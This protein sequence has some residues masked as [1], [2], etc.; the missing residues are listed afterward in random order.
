[1]IRDP[2]LMRVRLSHIVI[3]SG[4]I[5]IVYFNTKLRAATILTHRGI[6]FNAARDMNFMF[7]MPSVAVFTDE[8]PLLVRENHANIYRVDA[9]FLAKN[10]AELPQ[11][12]V[13]PVLYSTI[14]FFATQV[15]Q[16][17][18]LVQFPV[19]TLICIVMANMALSIGYAAACIFGSTSLAI[20]TLPLFAIPMMVYGGF[21]INLDYIPVYLKPFSYLSWY[22]YTMEAHMINM[23]TNVGHIQDCGGPGQLPTCAENGKLILK[24]NGFQ[25]EY[26][27]CFINIGILIIMSLIY[28]LLAM[29]GL[30]VRTRIRRV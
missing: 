10:I 7:M 18:W 1:M 27:Y 22:K 13:L 25:T 16:E 11:Y 24:M 6:L 5:G 19:F 30:F 15:M 21:F 17:N 28:R 8:L 23:W 29:L 20:Q 4:I 12:V 3:T 26:M 14:V 2:L 9:Y